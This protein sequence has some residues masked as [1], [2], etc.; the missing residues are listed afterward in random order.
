MKLTP[1]ALAAALVAGLAACAPTGFSVSQSV[2]ARSLLNDTTVGWPDYPI[3]V[4]GSESVGLDPLIIAQNLRFP[5]GLRADS[6]FRAI[7]PQEAPATH[8]HLAIQ[9]GQPL[10]PATLTFVHGTRRIGVGTFSIPREAYA[11]P[12]ALGSV[13]ATLIRDMLNESRERER[14]DNSRTRIR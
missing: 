12:R 13:S 3:I 2:I 4:E 7:T 10:A 11:D 5:A 1:L 6:S 9:D 14:D 8:A